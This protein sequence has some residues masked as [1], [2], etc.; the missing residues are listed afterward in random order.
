MIA[1]VRGLCRSRTS[2]PRCR[3]NSTTLPCTFILLYYRPATHLSTAPVG[4][5]SKKM[6]RLYKSTT[7]YQN[8]SVGLGFMIRTK[9]SPLVLA[10]LYPSLFYNH[11]CSHCSYTGSGRGYMGALR[12]YASTLSLHPATQPCISTLPLCPV[13]LPYHSTLSLYRSVLV[14]FSRL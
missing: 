7:H 12:L 5:F 3:I 2:R 8:K 9:A 1:V 13:T 11:K 10:F 4:V 6:S 14:L